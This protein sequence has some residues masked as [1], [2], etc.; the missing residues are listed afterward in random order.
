MAWHGM[1]CHGMAC[2]VMSCHAMSC[3]VMSYHV[4]SCY[5]DVIRCNLY[6]GVECILAVIGTG[7]PVKRSHVTTRFVSISLQCR[8]GPGHAGEGAGGV[9]RWCGCDGCQG[10]PS[11]APCN[12]PGPRRDAAQRWRG[13]QHL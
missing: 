12:L 3:H 9:A 11:A 1:R 2:D 10:R 13:A 4:M 8:A 7:G 5:Y 6:W